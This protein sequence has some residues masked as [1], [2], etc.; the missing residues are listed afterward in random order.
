M[1]V[2]GYSLVLIEYYAYIMLGEISIF[3][4]IY[5][6]FAL[7]YIHVSAYDRGKSNR[8]EQYGGRGMTACLFTKLNTSSIIIPS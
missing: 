7:V 4:H 5:G 6:R 1:N 2:Q 3:R 8:E